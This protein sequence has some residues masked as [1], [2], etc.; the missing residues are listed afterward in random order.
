MRIL[1]WLA[2]VAGVAVIGWCGWW[3]VAA[4]G[5]EQALDLWLE[6]RREDGWLAE[7]S[8]V[9]IG[10]FPSRFERR[11]EAPQLADPAAGWAWQAPFLALGSDAWDPT[12][13]TIDFPAVQSVAV[14]AGR[15]R[16]E[17]TGMQALAAVV[18]GLS[19]ALREVA[20]RAEALSIEGRDGWRAGSGLLDLSLA[21]RTDTDAPENTYDLRMNAEALLL[22]E[23][24][25]GVLTPE[26]AEAG[27]DATGDGTLEVR[28]IIIAD[29]PIDLAVIDRGEIGAETI[30]LRQTRLSYGGAVFEVDGRLD[31]DAEGFAE[32]TLN[33]AAQDWRRVLKA[34]VASGTIGEGMASTI[35]NA[36]QFV[37]LFAGEKLE[38]P[39]SFDD[40][41]IGIGPVAIGDAPRLVAR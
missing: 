10:G 28:G 12:H 9:S 7:V 19:L 41:R 8:A 33:V 34:L 21:R 40:G 4:T 23:R 35:R 24:L 25:A 5:Q 16:V 30:V 2:G 32:G 38:V 6:E 18:P 1:L 11:L 31:A 27:R 17:S 20:L 3:F 37:S 36:L 22:P 14:P 29:R 13:V 26:G 15:A 39:L